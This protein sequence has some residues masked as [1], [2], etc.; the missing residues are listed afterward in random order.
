MLVSGLRLGEVAVEGGRGGAA[1][2]ARGLDSALEDFLAS[3]SV[4]AV[5]A[6]G[7]GPGGDL[8]ALHILAAY[9]AV[10]GTS[11]FVATRT[12]VQVTRL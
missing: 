10:R 9:T 12:W 7:D 4:E 11:L 2:R 8:L 5:A 1:S 3:R 6:F